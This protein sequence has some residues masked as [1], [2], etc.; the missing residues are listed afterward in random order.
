MHSNVY[1]VSRD[2]NAETSWDEV[3]MCDSLHMADHC[4]E[5]T[6]ITHETGQLQ[7]DIPGLIVKFYPPCFEILDNMLSALRYKIIQERKKAIKKLIAAKTN[8]NW[9]GISEI[10]WPETGT[11]ICVEHD[12]PT[13]ID[14][15]LLE[16]AEPGI[17]YVKQ[18]FDYHY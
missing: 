1:V 11:F 18:V 5:L 4:S 16:Q 14:T 6:N 15:W 8:I 12:G 17:Y 7:N 13:H 3:S 2:K 9:W 10:A